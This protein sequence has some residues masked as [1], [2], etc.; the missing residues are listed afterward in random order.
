MD[1]ESLSHH[2]SEDEIESRQERER[3]L[4]LIEAHY[5]I[6]QTRSGNLDQ[7]SPK[8]KGTSLLSWINRHWISEIASCIGCVLALFAMIGVLFTYDDKT[9]PDWP[10]GITIN[11]ILSWIT[12]GFNALMLGTVATCLSQMPWVNLSTSN[13]P[14]SEINSY[15]W[16]SRGALGC[17]GLIWELRVRHWASLGAG[18]T[19]LAIGVGPFV[20]Q[21][22]TVKNSR[23]VVAQPASVGRAQTYFE[24]SDDMFIDFLPPRG[25]YSLPNGVSFNFTDGSSDTNIRVET[26][27]IGDVIVAPREYGDSWILN[28]TEIRVLDSA[29][30]TGIPKATATECDLY[31][32]VNTFSAKVQNHTL[33]E[34]ILDSWHDPS[35]KFVNRYSANGRMYLKP[36]AKDNMTQST[37]VCESSAVIAIAS[38]LE[39][40]L[41]VY[42]TGEY[43]CFNS[44]LLMTPVLERTPPSELRSPFAEIFEVIAQAMTTRAR[45]LDPSEQSRLVTE[46]IG[47]LQGIGA[48]HGTAFTVQTQIHVRW[49]WS[50][51]P[52]LVLALTILFLSYTV[53]DTKRKGLEAWKA[54]ATAL[55]CSGMDDYTQQRVRVVKDPVLMEAAAAKVLVRLK[56][57][58]DN[59]STGY[60]WKL[61]AV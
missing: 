47:P 28:A 11:S 56:K 35:A 24:S 7:R 43:A 13:R 14:L 30:A 9:I 41:R 12:Q 1:L 34:Q 40:K 61:Q 18:I 48:A 60:E 25:M 27:S 59:D 16:A 52:A 44:T 31:W 42:R 46:V 26:M 57:R 54:Y 4:Q 8:L 23:V 20:Q 15:D 45:Q 2:S 17:I 21:M 5:P 39:Y 10:G 3:S 58:K 33:S 29:N 37:F 19:I 51:L 55:A 38:W 32:C 49:A 22:V 53:M 36:P 6:L 50:A